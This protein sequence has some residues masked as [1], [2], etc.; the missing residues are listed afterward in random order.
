MAMEQNWVNGSFGGLTPRPWLDVQP[1]QANSNPCQLGGLPREWDSESISINL[2]SGPP[3]IVSKRAFLSC[4]N[5]KVNIFPAKRHFL[6]S[7]L[8]VLLPTSQLQSLLK[9][10]GVAETSL[11]EKI[12]F[13]WRHKRIIHFIDYY[14][15]LFFSIPAASSLKLYRL[16]RLL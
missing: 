10:A 4:A 16:C 1:V 14:L 9:T 8:L 7:K 11:A 6:L 15:V 2:N 5:Y 12:P 13:I 3:S